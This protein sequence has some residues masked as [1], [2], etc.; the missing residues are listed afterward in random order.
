M[1]KITQVSPIRDFL[2]KQPDLWKGIL[3]SF[4]ISKFD[5]S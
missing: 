4:K 2:Y 5:E 1:N 3:Q